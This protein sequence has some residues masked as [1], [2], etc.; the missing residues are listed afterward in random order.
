V[1]SESEEAIVKLRS[2]SGV[3][4][5]NVVSMY[6]A[7]YDFQHFSYDRGSQKN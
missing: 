3:L 7:H 5:P 4:I 1:H 6:T 2:L